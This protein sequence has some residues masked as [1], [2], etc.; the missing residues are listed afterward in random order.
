MKKIVIALWALSIA[1]FAQTPQEDISALIE[2]VKNAQGD[3]KRLLINELKLKLR[4]QNIQTRTNAMQ[5][6]RKSQNSVT[7]NTITPNRLGREQIVEQKQQQNLGENAARIQMY[8]NTNAGAGERKGPGG[9][10]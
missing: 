2:Q 5:A 8:K 7:T 3:E 6:L 9:R 1:L 10:Q 4:D